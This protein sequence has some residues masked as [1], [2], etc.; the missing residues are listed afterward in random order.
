MD[1]KGLMYSFCCN[2]SSCFDAYFDVG[3]KFGIVRIPISRIAQCPLLPATVGFLALQV[4]RKQFMILKFGGVSSKMYSRQ[5]W[6]YEECCKINMEKTKMFSAP[7]CSGAE[8]GVEDRFIG[9]TANRF[10]WMDEENQRYVPK[11]VHMPASS[12]KIDFDTREWE[13]VL[14]PSGVWSCCKPLVV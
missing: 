6:P 13:T 3:T 7:K 10:H 4:G 9:R 11:G 5:I 8:N 12:C 14:Q 1:V 2:I